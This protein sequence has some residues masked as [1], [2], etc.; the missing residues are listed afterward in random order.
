[1][2]G[3]MG[4]SFVRGLVAVTVASIGGLVV[5][6]PGP[7]AASH[8]T[9]IVS[10]G[11]YRIPYGD[12]I[13]VT[14][15]NDHHTHPNAFD[16]ID[17]NASQGDPV[18]AAASG[19]IRGLVD[20]HGDD[21]EEHSCLDDTT[22]VGDCSDYNNYVWIEHPN[23]EWTKY[24]HLETGSVSDDWVIGDTILV[25]Q[26]IGNESDVGFADGSHLHFEVAVPTDPTDDTPFSQNGGFIQGTN[27]VTFFCDIGGDNLWDEGDTY[28]AAACVNTAPTAEAGGPYVVDEGSTVMLDG[29]AS[30]DP[31][32]AILNYN[33]SPATHLDDPTIATPTYSAVDDTI[34]VITLTVDDLGGDVTALTVLSDDDDASVTVNNVAPTVTAADDTIDEGQDATVTATFSDPGTL[35]THTAEVDWGDTT[36]PEAV[37]ADLLDE[38]VSHTYGDN[39]A[40]TVTVT[41]TDDDGGVGVGTATV[42]VNNLDPTLTLDTSGEISFPGGDYQVVEAGAELPAAADGTD[43]GSDDLTFAWSVGEVNTYFNDGDAPDPPLSPLGVFPF[44]ASDSIDAIYTAPGVETLAVV[45]SDDDGGTD[46]ADSGVIVVGNAETTEGQG[47]WKH[48]YSGTGV[49]HIDAATADGYVEIVNAVSSVFSESVL[50]GNAADTHAVLS[51]TG[52]DR[53]ARATSELLQAWLQFASGAVSWDATVE[54]AGGGGTIDFLDLMFA[55]EAAVLDGNATDAELHDVQQALARVF[56]AT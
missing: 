42:T 15:S 21:P 44:V 32:N 4:R 9:F 12:G 10:A 22:V 18:V 23:G 35:D 33:W 37:D 16:R 43:P 31:H 8:G 27:R 5:P 51:P 46:N 39:G 56:H 3:I 20:N 34:D 26:E 7:A 52:D 24:T 38:G 1:M 13:D 2:G 50:L 19:V 53:R 29:T 14:A 41:V 45:L 30:S 40:Y 11:I 54:L 28:T 49:P 47:W 48:Q 17:L 6:T 55:A 25:G 36:P